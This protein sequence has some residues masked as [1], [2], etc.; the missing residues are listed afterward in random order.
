MQ[1]SDSNAVIL[2]VALIN[3]SFVCFLR[4]FKKTFDKQIWVLAIYSSTPAQF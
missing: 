1:A 4:N 2:H 3:I